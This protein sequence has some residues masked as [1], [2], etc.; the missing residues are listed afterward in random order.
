MVPPAKTKL[1]EYYLLPVIDR[2]PAKAH[3]EHGKGAV[4]G[5]ATALAA[6][7][8][9]LGIMAGQVPVSTVRRSPAL[10]CRGW[11]ARRVAKE[12]GG[13]FSATL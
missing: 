2:A 13:R 3:A 1:T 11:S 8:H 10:R 4:P 7:I 5:K 6:N 9:G 12:P